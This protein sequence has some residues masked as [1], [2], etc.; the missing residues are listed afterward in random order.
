LAEAKDKRRIYFAG[1]YIS[2]GVAFIGVEA[3]GLL[4]GVSPADAELQS[5]LHAVIAALYLLG[6]FVGGFLVAKRSEGDLV[7]AGTVSGVLAYILLQIVHA[8]LY[9]W[10]SI[11]SSYTIIALI[12][13]SAAGAAVY[14][15]QAGRPTVSQDAVPSGAEGEDGGASESREV[16]P[17]ET[18]D[19]SRDEGSDQRLY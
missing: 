13:G 7:Q 5:S 8:T 19:G 18:A 16:T 17:E 12:G 9:G 11:G 6:G 15:S 2:F 3:L 1:A 14:V 4:Y 10:G